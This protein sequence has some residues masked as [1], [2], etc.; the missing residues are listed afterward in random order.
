VVLAFS[1]SAFAQNEPQIFEAK[2]A[3]YLE[4][5]GA[6]GRYAVN[7]SRIIHQKGKLKLNASAGFSLWRNTYTIG[8]RGPEK[9]T[10]LPA[11]PIEFT[12]FWGKSNHHIELGIGVASYLENIPH[13]EKGP[14]KLTLPFLMAL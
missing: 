2:N 7:Y 13:F 10:W 9:T 8:L 11:I 6:S 3:V 4:F 1:T 5:G 14:N 12:A